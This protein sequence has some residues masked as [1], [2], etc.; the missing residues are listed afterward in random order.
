MERY[1]YLN[2]IPQ[3]K[4]KRFFI[5]ILPKIN[6]KKKK[7]TKNKKNTKIEYFYKN[8]RETVPA[9]IAIDIPENGD[10]HFS[11]MQ[12]SADSDN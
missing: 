3:T 4:K 11:C 5:F 9:I 8:Q 1:K 6:L 2:P 12:T 7:N 10:Y